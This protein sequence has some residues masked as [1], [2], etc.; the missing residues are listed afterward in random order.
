MKWVPA[1]GGLRATD[2]QKLDSSSVENVRVQGG[3]WLMCCLAIS[4][5]RLKVKRQ[6]PGV[7]WWALCRQRGVL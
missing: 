2:P 7:P 5:A 6:L 3:F 4:F 1:G